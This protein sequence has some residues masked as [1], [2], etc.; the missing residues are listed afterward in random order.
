MIDKE[1]IYSVYEIVSI[2]KGVLEEVFPFVWIEGEISNFKKHPS[3]HLYFSI[4]DDK[5][6][7]NA[8]MFR[9][10]AS[11]L[12]FIP[13]NGMKVQVRGYI[14]IYEKSG[15]FQ[16]YVEEMKSSGM[17]D[18]LM[19]LE[20]LKKKLQKEGLFDEKYKK[21]I[22]FFPKSIGVVTAK[23]GAAVR[24]IIRVTKRRAPMVQIIVRDTLVQGKNAAD[25][26]V[27]AIEEFNIY[28]NVDVLIVGRGGGSIEDLWAFNEEKVVRAIFNS[29]IPIISA[30][31]HEI[32]YTL[33]DFVADRRAPTPSAAAEIA[34]PNVKE[35]KKRVYHIHTTMVS[36]IKNRLNTLRKDLKRIATSRQL[37]RPEGALRTHFMHVDQL[38][39]RLMSVSDSLIDSRKHKLENIS[40]RLKHSN[41]ENYI[42]NIQNRISDFYKRFIFI[43]SRR[44]SNLKDKVEYMDRNIKNLSP[45]NVLGRGYAIVWDKDRIVKSAKDLDLYL[46][47]IIEL[48]DGKREAV[49]SRVNMKHNGGKNV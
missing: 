29:K 44:I 43:Q 40:I 7:I 49:I 10:R 17:G 6:Q 37:I 18:L 48:K 5:A 21:E 8:V 33:S 31:G 45:K 26:I 39:N 14:S 15:N 19:Q 12:T 38:Y 2:A 13:E 35:L 3:G 16:I 42:E 41:P 1:K 30:V 11:Y 34:V 22:P 28:K 9:G 27:M 46:K 24:D 32:D 25:D 4:K 47:V 20:M 36:S 23:S